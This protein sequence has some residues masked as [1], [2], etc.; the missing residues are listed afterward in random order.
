MPAS[1][2]MVEIT[3]DAYSFFPIIIGTNLDMVAKT[4]GGGSGIGFNL[5]NN[6]VGATAYSVTWRYINA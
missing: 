4:T 2:G 5:R 3:M 6:S 1:G